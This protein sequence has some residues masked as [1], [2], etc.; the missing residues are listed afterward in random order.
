MLP[1]LT[2]LRRHK[3]PDVDLV[4]AAN[5]EPRIKVKVNQRHW[6]RTCKAY[7]GRRQLPPPLFSST[8]NRGHLDLPWLDFSFFMPRG[9]HK[10]RTPPWSVLHGS[11]LQQ[12][13]TLR[14]S[15]KIELAM[16][17]GNVGSPFRKRLV[18]AAAANPGEILVNELFI[19]MRLLR[20]GR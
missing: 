4:I 13:A 7:P 18:A 2:L 6:E 12:S 5:D 15:E 16:H 3:I 17:T 11:M 8:T 1:L 19:G 10:L 20:N 14:W 9:D